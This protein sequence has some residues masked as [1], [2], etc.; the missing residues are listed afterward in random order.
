MEFKEI[1]PGIYKSTVGESDSF[2]PITLFANP[3]ADRLREFNSTALPFSLSEIKCES[4]EYNT[5]TIPLSK[6]EK[7]YGLGL[8]LK[9]VEQRG[10]TRYL[11]VNSDPVLDNGE[12][13][14][15]VPFY[16]S[17]HSYG[18]LI[19]TSKI[20]TIYLG[21]TVRKDSKNPPICKSSTDDDD[22][23]ATMLS[24]SVEAF[25][26]G[27]GF[28]VYIFSGNSMMEVVQ[29][30]VLLS[31]GG[32]MP[33]LWALGI[34]YR[35]GS[36]KTSDEILEIADD[37]DKKDYPLDVIGLEPGWHSRSYPDSFIW[38]K[39][40]F[41]DPKSFGDKIHKRGLHLNNWEHGWVSPAAPFYEKL[42][43]LSS[44]H[45]V[46]GGLAPDYSLEEVQKIVKD[47]HRRDHLSCGVDGYKIDE[48]DGSENTN[49]SWIF[50]PYAHFPSG[51]RGEEMRQNYGLFLQHMISDLYK[52]EGKRT[53]GLVRA[54]GSTGCNMPFVLYSD[55]Y[56]H[57]D[58]IRA[59]YNSSFTGLLW[60]PEVRKA[61]DGEDWARR[62]ESVIFSPLA[63]I[64]AWGDNTFPW[65]F[66]DVE[67]VVRKYFK[68]RVKLLPYIYRTYAEFKEYGIPPVR[69]MEMMYGDITSKL[70][71]EGHKEFDT[72]ACP[73]GREK[74]FAF[75]SQ[76][77]FGSDML[78]A[79]LFR[80]E[81]EREIYI[82]DG[83]WYGLET[84]ERI[85]GGRMIT[86]SSPINIIPVFVKEGTLIPTIEYSNR[87]SKPS[88]VVNVVQYGNSEGS[89]TMIYDD[90]GET[91]NE[92]HIWIK[93]KLEN[94]KI[95]HDRVSKWHFKK[96][97]LVDS[98][99]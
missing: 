2:S 56:D 1:Y 38:H 86:Y 68:I 83:I 40:R 5:I 48:C 77:F 7:L 37:F 6:D 33:P 62:I 12:T 24:D 20:V 94:G 60:T 39:D 57:R 36:K 31:G 91:T 54:S 65:T 99:S 51:R 85:E 93:L 35:C 26:S 42:E 46:W 90:D 44:D 22:W 52:E 3:K 19:D 16:V 92:D 97:K 25:S 45:T 82:P 89:E 14:A 73:Y 76:Y 53:W 11:R 88:E 63:M 27:C 50:P 55:L 61:V 58:Y 8:Q 72:V 13:H 28:D 69:S 70:S 78:V 21:S 81:K 18:V 34:W 80:G 71:K 67:E 74:T 59:L 87:A 30:Y 47:Q 98:I 9:S 49:C 84:K 17:S 32:A 75:E 4:G 29:K 79:P 41:K 64:N 96:F 23:K 43:A 95:E 10:K 15:P 66:K